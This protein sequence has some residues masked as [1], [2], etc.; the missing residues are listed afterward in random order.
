MRKDHGVI[1]M[2]SSILDDPMLYTTAAYRFSG[3]R[4][5]MTTMV[6]VAEDGN[7]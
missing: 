7:I 2:F 3:Q 4:R 5:H 1:C 6:P